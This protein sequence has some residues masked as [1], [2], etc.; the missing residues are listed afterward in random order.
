VIAK[1]ESIRP[2]T[3][4]EGLA[5]LGAV[6]KDKGG[7]ITAGNAPGLNDGAGALVVASAAYGRRT[8]LS[9]WRASWATAKLPGTR[10]TWPIPRRWPARTR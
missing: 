9:P 8:G 5:K 1:D 7:M 3:T 2:D 4:I 10:P 6:T